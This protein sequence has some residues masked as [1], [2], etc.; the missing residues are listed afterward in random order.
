MWNT[1]MELTLESAFSVGGLVGHTSYLLLVVSMLMRTMFWLRIFVIASAFVAIT[2]DAVWL[3]DPVG[4]FWETTLV[5]V[6]IVQIFLLWRADRVARFTEEEGFFI[7]T[8]LRGLSDGQAR[9]LMDAGEW[10]DLADGAILTE[11]G[12]APAH[13][14]FVASGRVGIHVDARRV[15]ECGPGAFVGEM[16]LIDEG[17]AS[18][19]A[20]AE[21]AARVWR[22]ATGRLEA[23]RQ[24]RPEQ[25]AALDAAIARDIRAK[26]VALNRSGGSER[27]GPAFPGTDGR[28]HPVP[29]A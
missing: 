17:T 26:L 16:S 9:R 8:R 11:Q 15:A 1:F 19:T 10:A 12:K 6:N 5:L 4:V 2:Y 24:S 13:L 18:A 29:G 25:T 7:R 28:P 23:L 27:H 21:G 14:V 22:I 20:R 3:K